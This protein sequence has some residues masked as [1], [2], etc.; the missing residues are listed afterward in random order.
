[1]PTAASCVAPKARFIVLEGLRAVGKTTAAPLLA[2]ELRATLVQTPSGLDDLRVHLDRFGP[3]MARLH[4]WMMCN[5]SVS[6]SVR[7]SLA[8]GRDV[9]V[10]S[11]FYRTLATHAAMGV[12]QLPAIDW[13]RAAKPDLIV[14]LTVDEPERQRRLA[15][16]ELATGRS[17]WERLEE[18]NVDLTRRTYASFG[19]MPLHTT[20][21]DPDEV[22]ARLAEL[23]KAIH[24]NGGMP[25]SI[26]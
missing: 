15:K 17:R 9:V 26:K 20:G 14:Q 21:L 12:T 10:E 18:S 11:Y 2:R 13:G 7:E 8:E 24:V 25:C 3:V 23:A 16:R 19:L 4:F 6:E 1:M 22:V 5:Y